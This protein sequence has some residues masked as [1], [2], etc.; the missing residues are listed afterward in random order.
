MRLTL[1][2]TRGMSL[3]AWAKSGL[4]NR[5]AAIY[6]RLLKSGW[7]VGFVTYGG[8]DDLALAGELAPIRVLA[9][10]WSLPG[11]A[12]RLLL[13]WLHRSWL[14]QTDV[15]KTNQTDGADQALRA[16]R[17]H[18]RPL[19]ARCGFPYAATMARIY[20]PDSAQ[21]KRGLRLEEKVFSG[22]DRVAV[23]TPAM[24]QEIETRL[25]R[26]AAKIRI[27]PNYVEANRFRPLE[28]R[29]PAQWDLIYVGRLSSEKNVDLLLR[30]IRPLDLSVLIIGDGELGPGLREEFADLGSRVEWRSRVDNAELPELLN[31]GC[32]FCQPSRFEGHPKALIEA[33][34][35]GL[36][37]VGSDV[38]G[39]REIISHGRNGLLCRLEEED[40]RDKIQTLAQD[41]ELRARLGRAARQSVEERFDLD[42]IAAMELEMLHSAA[43]AGSKAAAS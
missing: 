30:A 7:E 13:P 22:A 18:G 8:R 19:V 42:K 16:A 4:L 15:I 27:I 40:L 14:R 10:S 21:A 35:C 31:Q 23:T 11:R 37:V 17:W 41:P 9:N 39:I 36:A 24:A 32:I 2:F 20:G 29:P 12:Y 38:I 26:T 5:E 3:Q 6:R 34:S 43:G 33:M 28:P 25:P 1:F